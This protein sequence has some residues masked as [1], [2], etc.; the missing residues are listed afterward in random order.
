[1]GYIIHQRPFRM[2]NINESISICELKRVNTS[3]SYRKY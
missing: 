2:L 3:L 1:M